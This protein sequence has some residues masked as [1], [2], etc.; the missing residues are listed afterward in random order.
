MALGVRIDE[1]TRPN[2]RLRAL[3]RGPTS[4]HMRPSRI[5]GMTAHGMTSRALRQ[6]LSAGA[7][8]P[9][10]A[11]RRAAAHPELRRRRKVERQARRRGRRAA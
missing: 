8:A 5:E 3:S 4:K 9:H 7:L 10:L 11:Q 2:L 1:G 6:I